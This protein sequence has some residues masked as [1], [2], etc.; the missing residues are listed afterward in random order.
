[1]HPSAV[2]LIH[3]RERERERECGRQAEENKGNGSHRRQGD[4]NYADALKASQEGLEVIVQLRF[5]VVLHVQGLQI[6]LIPKQA[7][8]QG[9]TA[10]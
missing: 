10:K 6:D 1:M 7:C 5:K 3:G 9:D 2:L 4:R 8:P